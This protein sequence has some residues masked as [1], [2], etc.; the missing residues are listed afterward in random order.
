LNAF[1]CS[2]ISAEPPSILIIV[3]NAPAELEI[4]IGPE[5]RTAPRKD[6][7]IESYFTFYRFELKNTDNTIKVKTGGEAFEIR[8]N[9]PMGSY[10]N[11]FTLDLKN[12]TLAPGKSL[13]RSVT[14]V[15]LRVVLT[16]VLKALVLFIF[17]YRKKG[18]GRFF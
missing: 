15:I 1:P 10:N 17:G 8:I 18:R 5:Y 11:I 3:P 4:S 9:Y 16:L 6:K 2:A 14:L 13:S 7:S 12:R